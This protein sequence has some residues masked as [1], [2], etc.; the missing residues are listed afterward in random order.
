M[1][2]SHRDNLAASTTPQML[3]NTRKLYIYAEVDIDKA[4]S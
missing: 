2:D 4:Y 3:K 1:S